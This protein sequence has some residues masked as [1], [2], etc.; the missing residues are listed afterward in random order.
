MSATCDRR[1]GARDERR[2]RARGTHR[3]ARRS[4]ASASPTSSRVARD[5]R[6]SASVRRVIER[7][8]AARAIVDRA[9][10]GDTPVYGLN[11]A[12]GANTG[13]PLAPDEH[14]RSTRCARCARAPSASVRRSATDVVRATMFARAAGMARGRLGRFVAGASTRSS[15]R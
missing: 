10:E 2:R 6:R 4:G 8:R 11:S 12:L 1:T 13:E 15:T 5:V 7:L 9:A 3:H 14:A